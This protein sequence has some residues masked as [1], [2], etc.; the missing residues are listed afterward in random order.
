MR[1]LNPKLEMFLHT[2][3]ITILLVLC[4]SIY[5]NGQDLSCD[6]CTISFGHRMAYNEDYTSFNVS[7]M[8]LYEPFNKAGLC[9][10]RFDRVNGYRINEYVK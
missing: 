6:K 4:V 7:I 1:K 8:D 2:V 3:N 5:T 10:V 9:Y